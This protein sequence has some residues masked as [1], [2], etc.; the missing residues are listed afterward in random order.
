MPLGFRP[1]NTAC[2]H[3]CYHKVNIG[4][5][6]NVLLAFHLRLGI[7]MN[8]YPRECLGV[9]KVLHYGMCSSYRSLT[10]CSHRSTGT[11]LSWS[12]NPDPQPS[13]SNS[14]ACDSTLWTENN[15][16]ML[17]MGVN[18]GTMYIAIGEIM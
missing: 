3:S 4:Y 2:I 7:M 6:I 12:D 16:I 10:S 14:H 8:H 1:G 18:S 11:C 9:Q 15:T 17:L 13:H 5:I